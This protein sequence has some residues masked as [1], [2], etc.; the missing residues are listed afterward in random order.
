MKDAAAIA[1]WLRAALGQRLG[2]PAEAIDPAA[3]FRSYGVDSNMATGLLAEL[4][5]ALGQ[6]LSSVLAWDHP[7]VAALAAAIEAAPA[8][9]R[10]AASVTASRTAAESGPIAIIGM[11][12]RFPGADTPDALWHLLAAGTDM[13]REVPQ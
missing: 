7:T 9:T 12:C 3:R 13:I 4:G 2:M 1:A 5:T 6:P 11:A 8:E 10:I